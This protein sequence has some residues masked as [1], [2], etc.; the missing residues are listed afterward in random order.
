MNSGD[1]I[2]IGCLQS[3][4]HR[5]KR[6]SAAMSYLARKFLKRHNLDIVLNTRVI[7]IRT[8]EIAQDSTG[9][10]RVRMFASKEVMLDELIHETVGIGAHPVGTTTMSP[11]GAKHG[12]VDP[13]LL[14]RGYQGFVP[15]MPRL[16]HLYR[17]DTVKLLSI[18]SLSGRQTLLNIH[19]W[20][21][22]LTI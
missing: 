16:C 21:A 7:R 5:G 15:W 6:S 20:I 22:I 4:I 18:S 13:N 12:V 3:T 10:R 19:G 2:G 17:G 9:S 14:S 1:S 8:V 11:R